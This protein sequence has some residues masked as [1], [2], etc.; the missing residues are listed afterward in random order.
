M[1]QSTAMLG[2]AIPAENEG[3]CNGG[4]LSRI[5]TRIIAGRQARAARFVRPYLARM[6]ASELAVLGF[7][8]AE[9]AS[10][11]RDRHLPVALGL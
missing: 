3:V 6:P 9:I 2:R 1:S 4:I 11:R 5:A 7:S 10:L 8:N